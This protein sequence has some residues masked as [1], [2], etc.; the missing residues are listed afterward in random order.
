MRK[1]TISVRSLTFAALIAPSLHAQTDWAFYGKDPGGARYST[2]TQINPANVA[3]LRPV[4]T[5][6][7]GE[8]AASFETTPLVIGNVMYVSTP[9][10]RVVALDAETGREIWSYDLH[11]PR[12]NSHRGVSYWPGDRKTPARIVAATSDGRLFLLD[13]KTGKPAGGFGDNGV[14][15][16]RAGVTDKFPNALYGVSSPP[17][18][19]RNLIILGPRTQESPPKGPTSE[20]RAFDVFTGKRVWSFHTLPQPGEPGYETWAP[21]FWKDGS[22]PSAWAP[23]SLDVERGL[24]FVPTGQPAEGGDPAGRVGTNLYANCLLALDAATGKLKWYYQTVHHDVW[25]YDVPAQPTLVDVVQNGRK[26]PAVAQITKH[27][28]LFIL[29]RLTGQPIF[30]VEERP[31]PAQQARGEALWPKQPYPV[32]PPSLARNNMTADEI[33]R[34]TP[35]AARYCADLVANRSFEGAFSPSG[36]RPSIQFPATIGGGNWGGVSFDSARALIFVNTSS[37]GSL[38]GGQPPSN[39]FVDQDHY[40][41]NQPPWG[42]LAAVNANTGDVAWRV[43]LGSYKQLEDKGIYNAGAAN[44]GGPISTASGLVFI[45]ATNDF[46]FRAF[47]AQTGKQLWMIDLDGHALATPITYQGRNGRQYLGI[48]T[49]GPSYLN[50][51]GPQRSDVPGKITVFA[52]PDSKK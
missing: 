5:Y 38:V 10:E 30:G 17:A 21:D 26:I 29:N 39:R 44:L 7:P 35:E 37:L 49:G 12:P 27:G 20:I 45:G 47:D 42:E 3:A 33:S 25:D 9:R 14:V 4:W 1:Y 36:D 52:L 48:I 18:V 40:P 19:Y 24:V 11:V 22:G 13:A 50:G 6:D 31:V 8:T 46:R 43:P 41:C 32:K 51:V 16:L 15:N 23:L 34:I 2:L 28:L